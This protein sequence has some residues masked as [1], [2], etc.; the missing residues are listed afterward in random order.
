MSKFAQPS[1]EFEA[2]VKEY[3]AVV[4]TS[5]LE[6]DAYFSYKLTPAMNKLVSGAVELA[7]TEARLQCKEGIELY[8]N[9][10]ACGASVETLREHF[11]EDE[12]IKFF[13][14]ADND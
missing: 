6:K 11:A 14:E 3:A 10:E 4:I 1:E 9:W 12:L 13:L 5:L 7:F 8:F 2:I